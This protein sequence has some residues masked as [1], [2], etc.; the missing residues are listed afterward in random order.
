M[1]EVS[2]GGDGS[3]MWS[4]KQQ[5][6]IGGLVVAWVSQHE[7]ASEVSTGGGPDTAC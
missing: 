5:A 3:L 2:T 6:S 7:G 1:E 4:C